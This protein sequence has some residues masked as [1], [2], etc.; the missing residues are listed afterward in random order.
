MS[1]RNITAVADV[2]HVL[3]G[4]F[5]GSA[6]FPLHQWLRFVPWLFLF[7]LFCFLFFGQSLKPLG[8][9]RALILLFVLGLSS[10][11]PSQA[12]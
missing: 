10:G 6:P 3:S 8:K 9:I 2:L 1:A 7:C 5:C 11:M 12:V 4:V